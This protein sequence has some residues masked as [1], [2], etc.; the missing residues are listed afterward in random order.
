VGRKNDMRNMLHMVSPASNAT[1][2]TVLWFAASHHLT[3]A[4]SFRVKKSVDGKNYV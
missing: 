4:D 2:A 1:S 3:N